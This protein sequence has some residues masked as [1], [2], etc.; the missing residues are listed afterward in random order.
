MPLSGWSQDNEEALQQQ[1][2]ALFEA[3]SYEQA[4]PIYS[5]LLSLK[6]ENPEYNFR[7]GACQLFTSEDK[8]KALKYLKFAAS[9]D[10]A[11]PL[12]HFYYG[13]GL[14]L[15]YRFDR[16]IDE[17]QKYKEV[18]S[19]KERESQLVDNNIQ[20]CVSGKALVS[21]FTDISVVQ[22]EVLPRTDFYRNYDLTDFGGKIIIKPEDFMSEEDV[23]RDA[24]FLMYFQQNSDYIY[25][26]S[27]S[28]KNATGKDLYVIQKLPTGDWSTPT[29]LS[30]VINTPLDEDYAFIHP[31][32]SVLYFAS[33]GHNSMG[34]YDIFKSTRRGDGSWTQP[35]NMEFAINTPWD[36]FMF[37]TDKEEN[38]AWFA[39]N[40]E[41]DNKAV[42]LYKI[43]IQRVPLDLTLIKGTFEA[44]GSKRAKI[45]VEDM[46]QNKVVGVFESERQ[47]GG[48]LL[49]LRGSGKYQFIVEAEESS[50]VHRGIVEIPREKGLKQFRQEMKLVNNGGKEQLQIINHFDE[51]LGPDE[52]LLTAE[53]LKKQASLN[54][55]ASEDELVRTTEILDEGT[56]GNTASNNLSKAERLETA[57]LSVNE[58]K[59]DAELMNQKAAFLYEQASEKST[60]SN[61]EDIAEAAIAAELASI[62]KEEA[63]KRSAAAQRMEGTVN[64]LEG[65]TLGDE[66]FNAQYNQ[67]TNTIDN[68]TQFDE[69]EANIP[70]DFEKRM[71]PTISVYEEKKAEVAELESDIQ[72]ID[73]EI[74]YYQSELEN[75]KDDA[76]KEELNIQIEEAR[77][78]RPEK[79]AALKRAQSEFSAA[80]EQKS[81]ADGYFGLT[82]ALLSKA[83]EVAE[84]VTGT[85]SAVQVNQIQTSLNNRASR[86]PALVAFV[87]PE[88]VNEAIDESLAES[89]TA[90]D[91]GE[92]ATDNAETPANTSGEE[93]GETTTDATASANETTSS[94]DE[95]TPSGTSGET[96][97]N[98]GS[99]TENTAEGNETQPSSGDLNS[100]LREIAGMSSE[101]EIVR[102]DYG[103]VFQE[104]INEAANAED[105]IIAETRKAEIYDQWVDNIQYRIDSLQQKQ[106]AETD[107][108]RKL[109]IA[110]DIAALKEEKKAREDLAMHSY[111]TIAQ[112]SDQQASEAENTTKGETA[113][114]SDP[115][116]A[117]NASVD[118]ST[119]TPVPPVTAELLEGDG[120]P[121]AVEAVNATYEQQL[122][123]TTN[124]ADPK[125]RKSEEARIRK[126]WAA[127]LQDEV[128]VLAAQIESTDD[129]QEKNIL[130]RKQATVS[131]LKVEQQNQSTKLAKE[132]VEEEKDAAYARAQN[133]LQQQLVEYVE[134]YNKSAFEQIEQQINIIPD[135]NQRIVQTRTLTRNWIMAIQNEQVKTEA[136]L[137]STNDP[138]QQN[139][140]NDRLA[141][142]NAEKQTVQAKLA[143]LDEA[144][145]EEGGPD[146]PK[147]PASVVVKGSERY[148]GYEPVATEK[149]TEYSQQAETSSET[150]TEK[151]SEV[152][153]LEAQLAETKKKKERAALQ[154]QINTKAEEAAIAK[155][156][157]EFYEASSN[158]IA[159]V[160]P[161]LLQSGE[162][163]PTPSERQQTKADELK[164]EADQ[165]TSAAA[166]MRTEA[167]NIRKKKEREAALQEVREAEIEATVKTREA[168]LAQGLVAEMATIEQRTI[169]HN[170]II[171]PGELVALPVTPRQLNPNEKADIENTFQFK[172]YSAQRSEADSI[173]SEVAK[174][175]ALE[176]GLIARAQET[177]TQSAS[178][179]NTVTPAQ[180]MA[181]AD[182]AYVTYDQ[183]DSI[184]AVAARLS[185]E[186]AVIEN[187]ANKNLLNNPEEVYMNIIAYYNSST[188]DSQPVV[189]PPTDAE[190]EALVAANNPNATDP[191]APGNG[192]GNGNDGGNNGGATGGDNTNENA[193][194][195]ADGANGSSTPPA[196]NTTGA[197]NANN[198]SS[199]ANNNPVGNAGNTGSN[200]NTGNTGNTGTAG[201]PDQPFNLNPPSDDD[202]P[203]DVRPDVLTNTIFEITPNASTSSYSASN[204]IPIDPPLPTGL[205]YSVQIGAFRT[206][207][208]QD[209]FKGLR[210]IIGRSA[211]GGLTRY[212]AGQ[213]KDF[214][215]ADFAKDEVRQIGYPDA[216]V[217]AY[218][219][220]RR[221][222]MSEA[223]AYESGGTAPT[224]VASNPGTN[225]GGTPTTTRPSG[226]SIV[227]RGELRIQDVEN[228][229]GVF[230]TV[231][232]GVY[233]RP[234]S[235]AEIY[236]ITP[237]NQ[238]N[239]S[240]GRFRY[241]T[242][243]YTDLQ[244]ATRARDEIRTIG[245]RDAFVTA[246][247]NGQRI[248]VEAARQ[249]LGDGS[250]ATP[251]ATAPPA[252]NTNTASGSGFRV[253][254]GTYQGNIPVSQAGV[255]LQLSGQGVDK[256]KNPDGTN[257]Y[258]FGSFDTRAAAEA[259]ASRLKSR[260]LS[261][262]KATE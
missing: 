91:E 76:L 74:T 85:V 214:A 234:V 20:Q 94:S 120:L 147:A 111:E 80:E 146:A 211:G 138:N 33:Q 205:T 95:N 183:A 149:P 97:E 241:T 246:Y 199:S 51:P 188:A 135:E 156:E 70:K 41:T 198:G 182:Q 204:P 124:I 207:I 251:A 61:P 46:V 222:S 161:Q 170:F 31:E 178:N 203:V 195:G 107:T 141:L 69:F 3:E 15:N 212:S 126:Q 90:Q 236:N 136:R 67:L 157:S 92:G 6:L 148:E 173:R 64:S 2:L 48:Y 24:K 73:E 113:S 166:T 187:K 101:P 32:G 144:P 215:S 202:R 88:R 253:L 79:E 23:E 257:S 108:D 206:P 155:M 77:K 122:T 162:E 179:P 233:R 210:P 127:A 58:L 8:E 9:T 143:A 216:F 60:S 213:F 96:A 142:L 153:D 87:A 53:I 27:Y 123:Q 258:Y 84:T 176:S 248:T 119:D 140:L 114:T 37:I 93:S 152:D 167:E 59:G 219:N 26:A 104:E 99:A 262:A 109:E 242:G 201:N 50:A 25:Y 139:R 175:E 98:N 81:N 43:G 82:T 21:S 7:F 4:F 200:G 42:T 254:L 172:E 38:T 181:L 249:S 230:L 260:G 29:R 10:A 150:Y 105:P 235:S 244:T 39:S 11:P 158:A 110:N 65:A 228:Q 47:L 54:V 83:D 125:E 154:E 66:A 28:E 78:A 193:A 221:V 163:D 217:V 129:I 145:G 44:E 30:D 185:R 261:Q 226:P 231:Q 160:E 137:K 68:F 130:E 55:N 121:P 197:D 227:K 190:I 100:E 18:A 16:A 40:R 36:D 218:L 164:A 223:R 117:E 186:A 208:N 56:S 49:D 5:Q 191:N 196:G 131:D 174:L 165:L 22:R 240:D 177:L 72:G 12:S 75:T 1:A 180:R 112:L 239:M 168:R 224:P 115:A 232:V 243:I 151:Q 220:G 86:D 128:N 184:S 237:L 106:D 14:H 225:T 256:V 245:I 71:D 159:S 13:L 63:D 103:T 57:K 34:G 19:K 194:T 45:T 209:A 17:Y 171:P 252:G 52:S 102:G 250:T 118:T 192:V 255:I 116:N 134:D 35:I 259:E 62:Y 132:V 133:E 89:R 169:A 229:R 247:R 238:E 189:Q